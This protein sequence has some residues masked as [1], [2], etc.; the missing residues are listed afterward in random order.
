MENRLMVAK[1]EVGGGGM[2]WEFWIS[3][4]KLFYICIAESLCYIPDIHISLC[5]IMQMLYTAMYQK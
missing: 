3:K 5:Y 4:C 2:D 1:V